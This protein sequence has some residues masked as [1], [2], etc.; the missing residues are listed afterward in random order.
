MIVYV[1]TSVDPRLEADMQVTVHGVYSTFSKARVAAHDLYKD[2]E[3]AR[4]LDGLTNSKRWYAF[5]DGDS[6]QFRYNIQEARL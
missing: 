3:F 4:T 6:G 1:L 5:K 2:L